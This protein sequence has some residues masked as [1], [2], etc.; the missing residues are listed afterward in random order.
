METNIILTGLIGIVTSI[1]TGWSTYFFTR[2][3][4]NTEVDSNEIANLKQSLEFYENIVQDNSEKLKIYIKLAEEQ[5][6]EVYRLKAI[7]HRLLN[8]SCLDENCTIRQF[9]TKKQL[10][11]LLEEIKHPTVEENED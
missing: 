10:T 11:E 3:K 6:L 4:Y 9:Y 2:K 1:I 8:N 7:L 5:R